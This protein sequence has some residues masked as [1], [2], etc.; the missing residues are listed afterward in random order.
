MQ[1][2][3]AAIVALIAVA[4]TAGCSSLLADPTPVP[5][6]AATLTR[7][8][9]TPIPTPVR[10]TEPS[11]A[12]SAA[13]SSVTIGGSPGPSPGTTN[14]GVGEDEIAQVQREMEQAVASPDL[15]GIESLLLDHISL[16]TPQGGSVLDA[17]AAAAWLRDHAGAGIK[18]TRLERATQALMLQ[19]FS[20]GWPTRDPIDQG[21]VSF[22]LRR[23]D[24]N[25]RLDEETGDW[26]IDVI[27]AE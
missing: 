21:Q 11:P 9:R 17:T 18:V 14:Q 27:E 10:T 23:Y 2:Q 25:G 15:P 20:D 8:G 24:A 16:S 5:G 3:H 4:A 13:P 19:V 12:V 7:S 1:R 6:A 26:K 22:S